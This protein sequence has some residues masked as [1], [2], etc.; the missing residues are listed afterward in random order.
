VRAAI[1]SEP[2]GGGRAMLREPRPQIVP[3]PPRVGYR[4]RPRHD[5]RHD[6]GV[7]TLPAETRPKFR[8]VE[9]LAAPRGAISKAEDDAPLTA[10]YAALRLARN[11]ALKFRFQEEPLPAGMSRLIRLASFPPGAAY[12]DA[13][14]NGA[15]PVFLRAAA[16]FYL[17]C[18]LWVEG[19][20]HFRALGLQPDASQGEIAEAAW[21]LMA[22]LYPYIGSANDEAAF[23]DRVLDAWT[24]LR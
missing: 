2:V 9:K 12:A 6:V 21:I 5:G 3:L 17:E 24:A 20:S 15:N 4:E 1:G 22:W 10:L 16:I 18:V 14:F 7:E 23:A 8:R 11:P 13:K 19:G